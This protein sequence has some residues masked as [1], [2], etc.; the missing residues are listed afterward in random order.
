[1]EK[2]YFKLYSPRIPLSS[3]LTVSGF[4]FIMIVRIDFFQATIIFQRNLDCHDNWR[5]FIVSQRLRLYPLAHFARCSHC[6]MLEMLSCIDIFLCA[7]CLHLSRILYVWL[8]D[9]SSI[10]DHNLSLNA[11]AFILHPTGE[12]NRNKFFAISAFCLAAALFSLNLLR[13][14]NLCGIITIFYIKMYYI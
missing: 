3:H 5:R 1:M 6:R 9:I 7:V 10:S 8:A 12:C 2:K 13:L 11:S 14:N 4:L